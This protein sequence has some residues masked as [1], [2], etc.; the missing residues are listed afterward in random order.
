MAKRSRLR[1]QKSKGRRL[2]LAALFFSL[3]ISGYWIFKNEIRI[4]QYFHTLLQTGRNVSGNE[5]LIRGII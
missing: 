1:T 3:V 4:R 2:V 5:A